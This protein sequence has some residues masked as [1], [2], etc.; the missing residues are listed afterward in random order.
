MLSEQTNNKEVDK[1]KVH[2]NA[3][4][5][6]FSALKLKPSVKAMEVSID[7]PTKLIQQNRTF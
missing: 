6:G 3:R 4:E 7:V 5:N 2:S 1:I